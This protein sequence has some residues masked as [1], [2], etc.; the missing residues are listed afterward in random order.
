MLSHTECCYHI[1][2]LVQ[3]GIFLASKLISKYYKKNDICGKK[4]E[5]N[6]AMSEFSQDN[7]LLLSHIV[8]WMKCFLV[9]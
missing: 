7:V 3:L 2:N 9:N 1:L 6:V 5:F 8:L 4:K